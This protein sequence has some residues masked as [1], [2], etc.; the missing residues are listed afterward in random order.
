VYGGAT[1]APHVPTRAATD[2]RTARI[3]MAEL[4][5]LTKG[6]ADRYLT[7]IASATDDLV[8]GNPSVEQRRAA[9][10]FKLTGVT[11]IYDIVTNADPFSQLLDLVLVVTLQSQVWIDDGKA[12]EVFGD[13]AMMLITSLRRAREDVWTVAAR[14][15]TAEQLEVMDRLIWEWRRANQ[16]VEYVAFVR[17]DNFAASRGKSMIADIKT[18]TGFLAPV[19]QATKAVDEVR[20]LAERAFYLSK[21]VPT[22]LGWQAESLITEILA[23]PEVARSLDGIAV[24]SD[25]TTR[26]V[27]LVETLP[28]QILGDREALLKGLEGYQQALENAVVGYRAAVSETR[29]T[30]ALV[31]MVTKDSGRV[32]PQLRDAAMALMQTLTTAD[33]FLA[34]HNESLA[35]SLAAFPVTEIA[36]ATAELTRA[37]V[38]L[39]AAIAATDKLLDSPAWARRVGELNVVASG[40]I[41]LAAQR[42][43]SLVDRVFWR[44]ILGAAL[45]IA[46]LALYRTYAIWLARRSGS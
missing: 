13:R 42:S 26:V 33:A 15:M 2:V 12:D 25:T 14:V 16:D 44:V 31:G 11:S 9:L 21:R 30:V 39:N 37:L 18:G 7:L 20:L 4:D 8:K 24:L 38:Q 41:D 5:Q 40:G 34:R 6:Y 46:M 10:L 19:D 36:G 35:T 3:T 29:D 17:F 23:K 22:L 43:A 28:A 45:I 27:R 1:F 32:A